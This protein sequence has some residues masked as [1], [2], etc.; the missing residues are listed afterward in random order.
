[1]TLR[2]NNNEFATI[3][4]EGVYGFKVLFGYTTKSFEAYRN[5]TVTDRKAFKSE[6]T[7]ISKAKKYLGI[8]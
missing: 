1:M 8:N 3:I 6:K 4:N 7:A 5:D 2:N